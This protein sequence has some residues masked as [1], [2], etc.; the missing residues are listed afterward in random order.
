MSGFV[1]P[2][3]AGGTYAFDGGVFTMRATAADTEGRVAVMEQ[4]APAGLEVPGHVHDGEDEMFHVLAGE[5]EGFCGDER[6]SAPTG[7]F[8]FLPRDVEHGLHVVGDSPARLL[9]IVGPARFD[10]LV[11]SRGRRVDDATH[12]DRR[13][14]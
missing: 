9:T 7:A 3:G 12:E 10:G 11:R 1:L 5:V 8:I 6:W 13:T 14:P 2:P 4:E